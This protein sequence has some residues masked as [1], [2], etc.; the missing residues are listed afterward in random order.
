MSGFVLARLHVFYSLG[1]GKEADR[2]HENKWI[3]DVELL[4]RALLILLPVLLADSICL[5][6]HWHLH[7]PI[8]SLQRDIHPTALPNH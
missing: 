6:V 4:A 1:E 7:L 8:Q 2:E 5:V 3:G